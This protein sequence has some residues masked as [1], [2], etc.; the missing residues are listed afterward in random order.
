M[1]DNFSVGWPKFMITI[2]K[3]DLYRRVMMFLTVDTKWQCH[4]NITWYPVFLTGHQLKVRNIIVNCNRGGFPKPAISVNRHLAAPVRDT[5]TALKR[6]VLR[7]RPWTSSHKSLPSS[8]TETTSLPPDSLHVSHCKRNA[9]LIIWKTGLQCALQTE[10]N[11]DW[12]D[13]VK[14]REWSVRNVWVEACSWL[15]IV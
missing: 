6:I 3:T 10:M 5:L 7:P 15:V 4:Y 11:K 2:N 8:P 9:N 13:A 12:L 1:V 14:N